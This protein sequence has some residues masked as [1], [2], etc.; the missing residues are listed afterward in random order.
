LA[1]QLGTPELRS[2]FLFCVAGAFAQFG[3]AA[4]KHRFRQGSLWQGVVDAAAAFFRQ[5]ACR[6]ITAFKN[7]A[8]R[9]CHIRGPRNTPIDSL[10]RFS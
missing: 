3:A 9:F 6:R 4:S 5:G 7:S 8:S 1:K 10:A 2:G